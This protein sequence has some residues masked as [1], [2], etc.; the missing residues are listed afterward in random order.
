MEKIHPHNNSHHFTLLSLQNMSFQMC[1]QIKK[2]GEQRQF[3]KEV[4]TP[5][6]LRKLGI[7]ITMPTIFKIVQLH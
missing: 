5:K 3:F 4:I 1:L 2:K 7:V 6:K